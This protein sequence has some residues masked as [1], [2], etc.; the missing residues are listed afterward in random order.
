MSIDQ[1][2]YDLIADTVSLTVDRRGERGRQFLLLHSG[3]GPTSIMPLADA[4]AA[5]HSVIVPTMPGFDGSLRPGWVGT[6][7]DVATVYLALL[8]R[9]GATDVVIVGN[10]VG[11]WIAAEMALR[12]SSRISAIVLVDAAG[13]D[14]SPEAGAVVDPIKLGPAVGAYAFHDPERFG[15][16]PDAA[17]ADRIRRNQQVLQDYAGE[18]YMNDPTLRDRLPGMPVR[19]LVLWGESDRI[20]TPAY[21]RQFAERMPGARFMLIPEAGHFPQIEATAA[22]TAAIEAFA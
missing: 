7:G 8:E 13:L 14:P 5:R 16:P 10:S 2:S 4:L 11:G 18:P 22:V 6:I 3:A 12:G 20:V 21:G 17:A 15:V 9:M 19:S 1:R